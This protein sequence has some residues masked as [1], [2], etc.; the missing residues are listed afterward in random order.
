ML[1][2]IKSFKDLKVY[3][4]SLDLAV[5]VEVLVKNFPKHEQFLLVDQMR[6]ASR[7]IPPL[8]AEGY[9][10]RNSIKT[11][12]KFCRDAMAETNE[13]LS[14]LELCNRFGYKPVTVISNLIERYDNLG[15]QMH[16]LINNWQNF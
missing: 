10:K 4:D 7:A 2:M 3:Q 14:H 13:M 12:R 16:N 5:E 1:T 8:I 15:K 9:T 11:F 6:R